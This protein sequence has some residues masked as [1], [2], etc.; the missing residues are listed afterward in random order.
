MREVINS[1]IKLSLVILYVFTV[2]LL[3][4]ALYLPLFDHS[5][6]NIEIIIC[7]SCMFP[8]IFMIFLGKHFNETYLNN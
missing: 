1:T 5:L 4:L 6:N 7:F 3:L 8:L 2:V